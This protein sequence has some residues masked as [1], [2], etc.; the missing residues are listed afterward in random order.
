MK[1]F[2]KKVRWNFQIDIHGYGRSCIE[3]LKNALESKR[4]ELDYPELTEL[5]SIEKFEVTS[6]DEKDVENV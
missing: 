3:A 6:I 2:E 4:Y 5:Q 1:R